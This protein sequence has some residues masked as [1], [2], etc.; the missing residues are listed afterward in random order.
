[1]SASASASAFDTSFTASAMP[2]APTSRQEKIAVF[3]AML[4]TLFTLLTTISDLVAHHTVNPVY[5]PDPKQM[6]R[7]RATAQKETQTI[8][9]KTAELMSF[10]RAIFSSTKDRFTPKTKITQD[11]GLHKQVSKYNTLVNWWN[12]WC[13]NLRRDGGDRLTPLEEFVRANP[14]PAYNT[15][16]G[17]QSAEE[18]DEHITRLVTPVVKPVVDP[19]DTEYGVYDLDE[20][21]ICT[22]RVSSHRAIFVSAASEFADR[23]L[24]A[25]IHLI[26]ISSVFFKHDQDG[27]DDDGHDHHRFGRHTRPGR[28]GR[29]GHLGRAQNR[30]RDPTRYC[31]RA[32]GFGTFLGNSLLLR[33]EYD[34]PDP[35]DP[36]KTIHKVVEIPSSALEIEQRLRALPDAD[37]KITE[38]QRAINAR[39]GSF[40]RA[41]NTP[42]A[43]SVFVNCAHPGC[44]HGDGFFYNRDS[45][46][47]RSAHYQRHQASPVC[48]AGHRFCQRCL[49]AHDG[50]CE[51]LRDEQL[52]HGF[53]R[54][55]R[56]RIPI[57]KIDGCNHMTCSCGQHFCWLCSMPFAPTI[58]FYTRNE[59]YYGDAVPRGVPEHTCPLHGE[60]R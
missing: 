54:C 35:S 49:D 31:S 27:Y 36:A 33:Q 60:P 19:M 25:L 58:G 50:V 57:Q 9:E 16:T 47:P 29:G 3:T 8:Q 37:A 2:P 24:G 43:R 26:S 28:G 48:P 18:L 41:Q 14:I 23:L 15:T 17:F 53:R 20:T 45:S 12:I 4:T 42:E 21:P 40:F 10:F 46:N 13:A 59:G 1:M 38:Y 51:D 11:K 6:A 44:A 52:E 30:L 34:V 7:N 39:I 56:C 55:P 5:S 22:L 32:G